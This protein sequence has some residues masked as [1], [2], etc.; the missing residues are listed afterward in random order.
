M[1]TPTDVQTPDQKA[2][3]RLAVL[4]HI[5]VDHPDIWAMSLEVDES[6]LAYLEGMTTTERVG[7]GQQMAVNMEVFRAA[8]KIG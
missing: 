1:P 3:R 8:S 7:L 6:L 4:E 5:R 2:A